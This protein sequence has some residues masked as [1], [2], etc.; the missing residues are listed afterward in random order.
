MV[1]IY[2]KDKE[3]SKVLS[4]VEAAFSTKEKINDK[5]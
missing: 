4:F 3:T 5:S 1:L 2:Y